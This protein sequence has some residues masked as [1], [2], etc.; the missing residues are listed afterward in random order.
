MGCPGRVRSFKTGGLPHTLPKS[1]PSPGGVQP[2]RELYGIQVCLSGSPL[3]KPGLATLL[4]TSPG[5][6]G[7]ARKRP[8]LPQHLLAGS[9]CPWLE[10]RGKHRGRGTSSHESVQWRVLQ[11]ASTLRQCDLGVKLVG[12]GVRETKVRVLT[13]TSGK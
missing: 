13:G 1:L 7:K 10:T 2:T 6:C 11:E 9:P 3:S 4:I 8:L 5:A 12:F